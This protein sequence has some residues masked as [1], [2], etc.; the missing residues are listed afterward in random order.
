MAMNFT[1]DQLEQ[2]SL[3]DIALEL[4]KDNTE[5]YTFIDL[6]NLIAGV[7]EFSDEERESK[8]GIF[9]TSL[10]LDGRF[11]I[12]SDGSWDL[13]VRHKFEQVNP[14]FSDFDIEDDIIEEE[15]D[16]DEIIPDIAKKQDDEDD[17]DDKEDIKRLVVV[18]EDEI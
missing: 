15:E 3:T 16:E 6:F 8:L 13:R 5:K 14:D 9:Y 2:M 11:V 12:L 1:A 18:D 7:L 17:Y 4:L 10:T